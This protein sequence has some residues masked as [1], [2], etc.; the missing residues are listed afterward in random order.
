MPTRRAKS[1]SVSVSQP[2]YHDLLD[3]L[4]HAAFILSPTGKVQLVNRRFA[5]IFNRSPDELLG[6]PFDDLVMEPDRAAAE[7]VFGDFL[8]KKHWTGVLP[9]KLRATGET[10]YFDFSFHLLKDED[11]I[12]GISGLAVEI[13]GEQESGERFKQLFDTLQEGVYFSTPDGKLLDVN[14]A[15]ARLLGYSSR[16]ELLGVPAVDLYPSPAERERFQRELEQHATLQDWECT[17]K[18]KDGALIRCLDSASVIRDNAGRIIRYQGATV[19]ITRRIEMEERLHREEEFVRRLVDSSPDLIGVLNGEGVYTFVSSRAESLLGY[20]PEEIVGQS[21]GIALEP[22]DLPLAAGLFS[23]LMQ[24]QLKEAQFECRLRHRDGSLRTVRTNAGPLRGK[25][26]AI[27]GVVASARDVTTSKKLEQQIQQN[28]KLASMGQMLAGVAHELNNPLTAILGM[29][30]MLRERAT[31]DEARRHSKTVYKQARR[32]ANIVQS[33]LTFS[34]PAMSDHHPVHMEEIFRRAVQ[35]HEDAI[36]NAHVDVAILATPNL[37]PVKGEPTQLLQVFLNLVINAEQA[38]QETGKPGKISLAIFQRDDMIV[39]EV[40]DT[41][42]GIHSDILP[43]IFEPF[44]TTKRPGGGTGLGLTMSLALI[45]EHGGALEAENI[46]AGGALFR[47]S[48]PAG[49]GTP[50]VV[51]ELA[52]PKVTEP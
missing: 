43:R 6:R 25:D 20:K 7:R 23:R 46:R 26:G 49:V 41:G 52:W 45:K 2:G 44:F 38:I 42:P 13:R 39:A 15:M 50:A 28:E 29:S 30:E 18:R 40:Q 31:D 5:E 47:V 35:L 27:I 17:M 19:D 9:V 32:A 33:L 16:A 12:R 14:P 4:E 11:T 51:S 3:S 36:R 1:S 24:G 37:P 34:R 21:M 48:L 10:K 22:D 8:E